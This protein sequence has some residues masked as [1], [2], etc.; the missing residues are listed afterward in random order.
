MSEF[1][2]RDCPFCGTK[3]DHEGEGVEL[4]K[5]VSVYPDIE[6]DIGYE[7]VCVNCGVSVAEESQDEAIALWNGK[8][9]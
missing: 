2:L 4:R 9:K 5:T 1:K 6:V 7:V 3:R 8:G